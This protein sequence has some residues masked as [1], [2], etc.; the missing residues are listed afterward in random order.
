LSTALL[1]THVLAWLSGAPGKLSRKARSFL[2]EVDTLAVSEIVAF[3]LEDLRIRGRLPE[4][5]SLA[6]LREA[7]DLQILPLPTGVWRVA[8][9]LPPVHRDSVDRMLIAH[10]IGA[11]LTLVSA[12]EA[13]RGYPVRLVW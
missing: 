12:D 10:A 6:R 7:F 1:D 5:V 2:E 8:A 13:M 9:Q 3:E 4:A 11:D